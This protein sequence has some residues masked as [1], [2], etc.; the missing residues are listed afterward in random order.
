MP[1]DYYKVLGVQQDAS[2]S[3]IKTRYKLLAKKYHPDIKGGDDK[4]MSSINKAYGILSDPKKRYEY[5]KEFSRSKA[6]VKYSTSQKSPAPVP[7]KKAKDG[8]T[9]F[10]L[11]Q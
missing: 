6:V 11:T 2:T 5:N 4:K 10:P 8:P 1:A 7:S 3:D 9:V